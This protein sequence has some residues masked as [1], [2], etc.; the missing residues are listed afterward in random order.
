MDEKVLNVALLSDGTGETVTLLARACLKQFTNQRIE[1]K[2]FNAL[3]SA[4]ELD[5]I[6]KNIAINHDLVIYTFVHNELSDITQKFSKEHDL[7]AID[8]MGPIMK[9]FSTL[10]QEPPLHMPGT[11]YRV[12]P[13]YFKRIEA[14]EFTLNHDHLNTPSFAEADIVLVGP[15]G[16]SKTPLSVYLALRGLKVANYRIK[17]NEK[18]STTLQDLDQRKIF[19]LTINPQVL[20]KIREQKCRQNADD[21]CTTPDYLD[22]Q[23]ITSEIQ[24]CDALYEQNKRWPKLNA[25]GLTIEELGA[26]VLKIHQ[27]REH[28]KQKQDFREN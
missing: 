18:I 5:D 25:S 23:Q 8:V 19:A 10:L 2:R 6:L 24:W 4:E 17:N 26:H 28:N 22:L 1:L 7:V 27:M 14:I 12:T 11:L 13:S 15:S 16:T 21:R 3:R 9:E 20:K